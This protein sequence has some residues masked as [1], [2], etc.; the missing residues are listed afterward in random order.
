MWGARP[1]H[2]FLP[3]TTAD[4][5]NHDGLEIE[6]NLHL[7]TPHSF[8]WCASWLDTPILETGLQ[9]VNSPPLASNIP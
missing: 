2:L 7:Q 9:A 5:A 8:S 6:F 1:V 4:I 3:F